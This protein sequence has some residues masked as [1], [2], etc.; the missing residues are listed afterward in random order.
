M[1]NSKTKEIVWLEKILRI[2]AVLVLKK[3]NPKVVSITGSVGKTS[4][5]EVIYAVLASK[6]RV[7]KAE[8]NYNNEIGLP[9]TI[10]GVNSGENSVLKWIAVFLKW[11]WVMIAPIEYPEILVLEMGADRPGDI[12][13]LTS[14]IKSNVGVITDFSSSHIEFF[15]NIEGIA[16]EK[17]IL[18]K[19]LDERGLA[20]INVDNPHVAKLNA[21]SN[22]QLKCNVITFGFSDEAQMKA[23]DFSFS[24]GIENQ[25]LKGLSFKLNYKGTSIPVRLNNVL[26]KHQI[27]SALAAVAVGVNFGINLVEAGVALENFSLPPGR[28]NLVPGIKGSYIVDDTYNSSPTSALAAINALDEIVSN[29]KKSAKKIIVFGDM[30]ELGS[31]EEE[32]HRELGRHIAKV[33]CAAFVAVGDRMKFAGEEMIKNDFPQENIFYFASPMDGAKKVKELV[34]EGDYILVKGSQGMRMEKIVEEVMQDPGEKERLLC[35]QDKH[36]KEMAWKNN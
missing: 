12:K 8:K 27:Y 33:G 20:V 28:M 23:T 29:S 32:R 4:A 21:S 19:S 17:S 14:F 5:K 31:E 22:G 15:K 35:R 34:G 30:L 25:D 3:Y 13:Y 7:R 11:V 16:K 9:L 36:W 6:F 1:K 24:Y 2:M 10:I 18:V 26:A